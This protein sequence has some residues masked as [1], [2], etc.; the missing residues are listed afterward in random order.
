[1]RG[2]LRHAADIRISAFDRPLLAQVVNQHRQPT[3]TPAAIH[4]N[5][6]FVHDEGAE[7]QDCQAISLA[8]GAMNA[9]EVSPFATVSQPKG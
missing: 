9:R 8:L 7:Q 6:F 5:Q 3:A 1:M 2:F 4:F